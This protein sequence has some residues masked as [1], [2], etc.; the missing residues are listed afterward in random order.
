[1][2]SSDLVPIIVAALAATSVVGLLVVIFYARIDK[3]AG[4]QKRLATISAS[5]TAGGRPA[6][7]ESSKRDIERTLR[8]MEDKQ[9]AKRGSRPS[10][11]IRMRQAGL[12]WS[13]RTYYGFCGL[14]ALGG[15]LVVL[16][17][18]SIALLPTLGFGIAAGLLLPHFFVSFLRNRRF[19]KFTRE[20]PNAIDVIVRGIKSGLPVGDCL[21]IISVESQEPVRSE[22]R[23]I[24]DDQT[25]GL[26]IDQ[27][28]QR[29]PSRIPLAEAQFFSIVISMQSRTGGNLSDALGGLS[30]VL[31]DRQKMQ[32][33]IRA[34]SAEAKTS[35]GIIGA[36]P[37]A[38]L[39][40]MHLFSPAYIDLLF[41]TFA[42]NVILAG[43]AAL[44][45]VGVFIMSKMI[46][47]D[48]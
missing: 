31:R 42:G 35:A 25:L 18:S 14:S 19:K 15:V 20:F 30:R 2:P 21:R 27:A 45:M 16:S 10:L 37:I 36:L 29:L 39:I 46:Q 28:V 6:R 41:V 24:I 11:L 3:N 33:K 12:E 44:M 13:T 4:G 1:M 40:L 9:K 32:A 23:E 26:P 47:F 17:A 43:C 22:F 48:F 8:E 5:A 7:P 38:V 34:M